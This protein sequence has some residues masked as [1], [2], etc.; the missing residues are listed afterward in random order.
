M[1]LWVL[2]SIIEYGFGNPD[3]LWGLNLAGGFLIWAGGIPYLAGIVLLIVGWFK[4]K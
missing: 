1:I 4:N 3:L 2:W